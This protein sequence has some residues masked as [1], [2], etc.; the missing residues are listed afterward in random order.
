MPGELGLQ[1]V[2]R[3]WS[4]RTFLYSLLAAFNTL[5]WL[6][7]W[8]FHLEIS[9]R[10]REVHYFGKQ[11]FPLRAQAVP[12]SW[13]YAACAILTLASIGA[14]LIDRRNLALREKLRI[15]LAQI[16][17]SL[18]IGVIVLDRRGHLS[19][20]NESARKLM[21]QAPP[22]PGGTHFSQVLGDYPEIKELVASSVEKGEYVKE[23][24]H[25]LGSAEDSIAVRITTLPLKD[26]GKKVIGTLLLVNNVREVVAMEQQVRTAERLSTL[27]TL[28]A[29][30]AHEI[31]NPLE[32]MN[33][34]LEL[35][36]RNLNQPQDQ[37]VAGDKRRKYLG[38]LGAEISRLSGILDNFLSFARPNQDPRGK[39][40]INDILRQ[41]VDL[42]ENQARS[43]HVEIEFSTQGEYT[44][45]LGSDD[46]LKQVFL[47]LI[48]NGLQAM[49]N[50]GRLSVKKESPASRNADSPL[51]L[52][53]IHD[54][55]EG[56]PADKVA[57]LFDPFFTL[58][59]QGSGLGLTVA[60]RVIQRHRG[61][62]RV[63]SAQG[64][65]S[66]FTVELP[67]L[68]REGK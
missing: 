28:A 50:G 63:E 47:N 58:K 24:E 57:H 6:L 33:L 53:H 48:I 13:I 55:G 36:E 17:E 7:L 3:G 10:A 21:P 16:L 19:L 49:P 60:H 52:V 41:V 62:I 34:N 65:G 61:R 59:P 4:P 31:R 51:I 23:L 25:S 1:S 37:P 39:T 38:V 46:Q 29:T 54:T 66:T 2:A 8:A 43:R 44:D 56:I 42:I 15:M 11:L 22:F 67:A 27:G 30:L 45:V 40:C 64:K 18:E 20:T 35:L 32:A 5:I 12:L 68:A 14:I 9:L 26:R